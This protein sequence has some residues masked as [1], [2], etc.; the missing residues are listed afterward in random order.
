MAAHSILVGGSIAARRLNCPASFQESLKQP[1]GGAKVSSVYADRG[2]CL[3]EVMA[4][5]AQVAM[6]TKGRS[7][8]DT[9]TV[10]PGNRGGFELTQV[11]IDDAIVPTL[12]ALDDL[13]AQHGGG[14]RVVAVEA[15]VR[16]PGLPAAF[17]TVDLILQSKSHV[18]V[19]DYKFGQG[20]PVQALYIDDVQGDIVN[21]QLSYY[22]VGAIHL[23]PNLFRRREIVLAIIQPAFDPALTQTVT[24][25]QELADFAAA[26]HRAIDEALTDAP[27]H[28]R[29]EWCRFAECKATCPLWTGPLLDLSR[30]DPTNQAL[31]ASAGL[32]SDGQWGEYLA[33]AKRLVDSAVQYKKTIDE[34]LMQ[35][36]RDGGRA[37][38]F[39]LK[40]M[41]KDRK[42]IDNAP[43]VAGVLAEMGFQQDEIWQHKLQTFKVA[44][45]AA[46]RLG[47]Q[48]PDEL[49]P[50]PTT[51]DMV[52]TSDADPD[53]VDTAQLTEQFRAKLLALKR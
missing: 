6:R 34:M 41:V 46:K 30:L 22:A 31:K 21:E 9:F 48:I 8:A 37:P 50:R 16:F 10:K 7:F 36:L 35:H 4:D 32:R 19:A 17:G 2:T 29:G 51:N 15:F 47:V 14:F 24:T 27:R 38:G 45:A 26:M 23:Y 20:V 12:Q 43:V 42:W 49:R 52:L 5:L 40:P 25:P 13:M 3:H 18:I 44:D 39:A 11:D 28:N 1:V 53:A 33:M